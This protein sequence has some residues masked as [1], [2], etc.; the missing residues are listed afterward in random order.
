MPEPKSPYKLT[1]KLSSA[2]PDAIGEALAHLRQLTSEH[3]LTGESTAT[4]T[5]ECFKE[6]PLKSVREL[7]ELWLYGY[8]IALDCEVTAKA[9]GLRPETAAVLRANN[10]TP[11]DREWQDF[12]DKNGAEVSGTLAGH[13]L[14]VVPRSEPS[15]LFD[16]EEKSTGEKALEWLEAREQD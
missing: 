11:M 2:R 12:A 8:K 13:R 6:A 9:P 15:D 3:D 10:A 5:I 14:H 16:G 4:L 7:F 1:V